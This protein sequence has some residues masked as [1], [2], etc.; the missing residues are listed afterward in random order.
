MTCETAKKAV[1]IALQSPSNYLSFEFQGGE[2]LTNFETIK[3]IIEYSKENKSNKNI[4]YNLVSNLTLLTEEMIEF[5]IENNV[6]IC[7][8]SAYPFDYIGRLCKRVAT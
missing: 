1:G 7:R 3:Y 2:P 5:F 4:D 8:L 6:S